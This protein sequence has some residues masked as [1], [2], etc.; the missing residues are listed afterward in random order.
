MTRSPSRPAFTLL[1][2][3]LASAIGLLVMYGVYLAIDVQLRFAESGRAQ[4][5]QATLARSLMARI[6]ADV[7]PSIGLA[8]PSRFQQQS[9]NGPSSGSSGATGST[10]ASTPTTGGAS[11]SGSTGASSGST[12]SSS[13]SSS[14]SPTSSMGQDDPTNPM[15]GVSGDATTLRLWIS[16]VPPV[17]SNPAV[18]LDPNAAIVCD[19]RVVQYWLGSN[20]GL[21]R[22]EITT[23][24]TNAGQINWAMGGSDESSYIIAPEV[25]NLQ[26]SYFDGTEW[27]PSWNSTTPGSDGMTPQGPPA[28]IAVLA[29][30]TMP[31][32]GGRPPRVRQFR[33]VI[34]IPT[35]NGQPLQ[36]TTQNGQS[37]SGS[38]SGS[39][40][41]N[42]SGT[43]N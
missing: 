17:L 13:S 41:G 34:A 42:S 16:R 38:G 2:V 10:G 9:Q 32:V 8:D 5:D 11:S 31:S 22:Q 37:G 4:V 19:Q 36:T 29:E 15:R 18:A 20:G 12:G 27:Q 21:G 24:T 43:G 3:L 7:Q 6:T 14:T 1:E 25:T 23:T 26:F 40:G 30:I 39:S 28:A 35:A 33:H